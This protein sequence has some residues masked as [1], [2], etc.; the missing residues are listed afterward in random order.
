MEKDHYV[1]LVDDD[2]TYLEIMAE[3]LEGECYRLD[4]ANDGAEAWKL[5]E[6]SPEKYDAV[7]LDRIMPNMGGM[8]VLAKMKG[9]ESLKEVPVILETAQDAKQ[10]IQEGLEAG[11]YYYLTKP[12]EK[13]T[14]I[15]IVRT[16][17]S[18][19]AKKRALRADL[20]T[21]LGSFSLLQKG[22]YNLRTLKEADI[23]STL[24]AKDCPNPGKVVNGVS[25]LLI[26]AVEHG[27]LGI[28]YDEKSVLIENGE[29]NAEVEQRLNMPEYSRKVVTLD[30][31][32]KE[33]EIRFLIKDEGDGFNWSLYLKFDPERAFDTHGRGIALAKEM[34]FDS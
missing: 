3:H 8:E 20:Q 11:A 23:L 13:R 18:D 10:E 25:E 30:F 31:E 12:F 6:A 22:V 28:T 7:L 5:L 34:S 9:H 16:A 19:C 17:V 15:A 26:N 2:P 27:N 4:K 29:L 33:N 32:R 1:L 14:L 24:L 21:T